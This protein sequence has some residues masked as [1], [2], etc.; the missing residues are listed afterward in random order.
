MHPQLSPRTCGWLRF[1][2][3]KATTPDDWSS[4]GEPHPW[5][6][7]SSTAPMC[8]IPRFDLAETAYIL[9][10]LADKTPAWR[11]VYARVADELVGRH[12]TFW[13]AI[14]WLTL[15]GHDPHP[16][17]YPPE[18]LAWLPPHLQGRYDPPGWTANGVEPW[19]LQPDPIGSDGNLFFRGFF[20]LLLSVYRYVA[21]DEKWEAPFRVAGYREQTFEWTHHRIAEFIHLQW[22]DRPQGPHCEN[23]KIWPFCV[24]GAGLGLR[25]Y[26]RTTGSQFRGVYDEWVEFA[27]KHYMKLDQQGRIVSFPLYYDPIHEV[28]CAFP[29]EVT[30]L[31]TI[32]ITPYVLPQNREFGELLYR[33]SVR[34]LG[35]DNP[36]RRLHSIAPDPRFLGIGLFV[37][38][39]LG[40]LTTEK[41]IREYMEA[42]YE[43]RWF[44]D[45]A[46]RFG[47]WF[48]TGEPYP[49]G[50]LSALMMLSEAGE[51]GAWT[52]VFQDEGQRRRFTDPT[53]EGIDYPNFGVNRAWNDAGDGVLHVSTFAATPSRRKTPTAFRVTKLAQSANVVV[54]RDGALYPRWRVIGEDTI[55]I[56][57]EIDEHIFR[58]ETRTRPASAS[59]EARAASRTPTA[60]V[61]ESAESAQAPAETTERSYRPAAPQGC[62]C[63]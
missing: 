61:A 58:I 20:N 14:D 26:D 1:I 53:V 22:K 40:D 51:A 57:T 8:A 24:S 27:K 62:A 59:T 15:I 25:L 41:R 4:N 17:A 50:Q 31:G 16:D 48:G 46:T 44:G 43:P 23:T 6:D 19:G 3:E 56:E 38:H 45:D 21:G 5:W 28:M 42:R 39:E 55:E 37:A 34:M 35:W 30:G 13:A 33:E 63:C 47:W 36:A 7:R 18:W 29:N 11:E 12:T 52:R 60:A 54:C 49:R 32:A 2:W 10:L 9:P